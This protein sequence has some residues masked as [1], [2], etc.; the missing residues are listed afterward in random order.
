MSESP[1]HRPVLL[2]EACERLQRSRAGYR[3]TYVDAT[4]GRG[5]HARAMLTWLHPQ[6]GRLIALDRDPDAIAAGRAV[7]A[8]EARLTLCHAWFGDLTAVL[9]QLGVAQVDGVLMDLGVS[10]PQLDRAGRG[11]SFSRPGPLD[12]RMDTTRGETAAE[13]LA[14][15]TPQA[16]TRV[17]LEY[18]EEPQ[19]RRVARAVVAARQQSPIE[20]T[21][22]LADIVVGVLGRRP[23]ERRHPA[24]RVFQAIRMEINDELGE[25][26]RGL[27]SALAALAP[28][29]VLCVI[30]FH[31]LED[32]LVKRFMRDRSRVDPS[33]AK[34]PVVP[35][36]AAPAL[37]LLGRSVRPGE[38][39]LAANPR[40]RSAV[41]RAAR[42]RERGEP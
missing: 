39:E 27:D 3:G 12:M 36:G 30:S 26:S 19:A 6:E 23:G 18:G 9:D 32:R 31:S 1:S 24:T 37:E 8:D 14:R 25:L 38:A 13:W 33:L 28:G 40:A 10:S 17:L 7:F 11:F 4:F 29:G 35:P 42:R 5:G 21:N 41:L 15:V 20:T 16:L 22:R 34:L 2:A